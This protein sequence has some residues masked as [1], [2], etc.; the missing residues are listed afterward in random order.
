[1]KRW[2]LGAFCLFLAFSFLPWVSQAA[3]TNRVGALFPISG[4]IAMYGQ[5]S[6]NGL[7]V[8]QDMI[9]E[10]GGLFGKKLEIVKGDAVDPKAAINEVTRLITQ[11]KVPLVLGTFSSPRAV[12]ASEVANRNKVIYWECSAEAE[13]ITG[14][15]LD[16]VFRPFVRSSTKAEPPVDFIEKVIA[17]TLKKDPKDLRIATAFDQGDWG[18]DTSNAFIDLAKKHGLKIVIALPH[19]GSSLDFSSDIMKLKTTQPDFLFIPTYLE[20]TAVFWRQAKELN[21][22]IP[23]GVCGSG[24]VEGLH[25]ILKG[26]E[27]DYF[28]DSQAPSYINPAFITEKNQK[29]FA[30]LRKRYKAKFNQE[31]PYIAILSFGH[32]M[33]LFEDVLPRAKSLDPEAVRKA[34]I[35]TDIPEGGTLFGYGVK[36]FPPGH[37]Q[38]GQ[39]ERV[40]A[41][42]AQYQNRGMVTVWP[43]KIQVAKPWC[44]IPSW[45]ER[46]KKK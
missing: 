18:T 28:L 19:D 38:Q 25:Q 4:P 37:P 40:F 24:T 6:M 34:A 20:T 1:M 17:P 3:E 32:S 21:F 12:P 26:P 46:D 14:R 2:V 9:N 30:E 36:F 44:P 7:E 29:N 11:E 13:R 15:N 27:V 45:E 35:A 8:A 10:R 43:P 41:V 31:V 33:I 22:N 5:W 23:G 42:L 39:N 16:Y